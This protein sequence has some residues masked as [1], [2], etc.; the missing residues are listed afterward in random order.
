MYGPQKIPHKIA[1]EMHAAPWAC[2]FLEVRGVQ[3]LQLEAAGR[4]PMN[5]LMINSPALRYS[6]PTQKAG[7][8]ERQS[9]PAPGQPDSPFLTSEVL[10]PQNARTVE[11]E[12]VHYI[13]QAYPRTRRH[14]QA[15]GQ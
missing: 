7:V 6:P 1:C 2:G 3:A 15:L 8:S 11:Q 14:W 13:Q 10:V 12:L 4:P 9:R 5:N